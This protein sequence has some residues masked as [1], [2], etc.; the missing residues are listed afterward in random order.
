MF[1]NIDLSLFQVPFSS[2]PICLELTEVICV[3]AGLRH[4]VICT[5]LVFT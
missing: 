3:S 4:T 5:K 2:L 1:T